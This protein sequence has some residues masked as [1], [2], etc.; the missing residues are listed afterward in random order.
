MDF[1]IYDPMCWEETVILLMC[2]FILI[3][4]RMQAFPLETLKMLFIDRAIFCRSVILNKNSM[5]LDRN[6]SSH[7]CPT[8]IAF[9]TV[10]T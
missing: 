9:S 2:T 8:I 3:H 10:D 1:M 7:Q 4:I 6:L 5:C